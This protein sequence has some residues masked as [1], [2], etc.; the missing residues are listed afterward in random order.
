METVIV[1]YD[2]CGQPMV[3]IYNAIDYGRSDGMIYYRSH[4]KE[5]TRRYVRR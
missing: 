4:E 5:N 2:Y 3:F 1:I